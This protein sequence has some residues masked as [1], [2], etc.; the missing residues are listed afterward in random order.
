[1]GG[2]AADL[3]VDGEVR[4]AADDDRVEGVVV[5]QETPA[6]AEAVEVQFFHPEKT[7]L[8]LAAHGEFDRRPNRCHLQRLEDLGNAGLVIGPENRGARRP[9][10]PV[11]ENRFDPHSRLH[12]IAVA[13]QQDRLHAVATDGLEGRDE[14]AVGVEAASPPSF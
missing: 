13:R 3:H 14:V 7:D 10:D 1:M 9:D 12:G 5:H 6:S 8:L 11:R 4:W 2:T